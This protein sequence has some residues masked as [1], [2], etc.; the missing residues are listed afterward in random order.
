ME[1]KKNRCEM[2]S[3]VKVR[4]DVNEKSMKSS[5]LPDQRSN[6]TPLFFLRSGPALVLAP[7]SE[8]LKRKIRHCSP[9]SVSNEKGGAPFN[10][11]YFLYLLQMSLLKS[12]K[13]KTDRIASLIWRINKKISDSWGTSRRH[14]L[15]RLRCR[16]NRGLSTQK[17]EWMR[18]KLIQCMIL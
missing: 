1:R 18:D 7:Y 10:V 2:V 15:C 16:P 12:L 4:G 14:L 5:R 17:R 3:I 9:F 11:S 8:W 6:G 13:K